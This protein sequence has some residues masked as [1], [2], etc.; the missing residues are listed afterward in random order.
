MDADS[1][2]II[3]DLDQEENSENVDPDEEVAEQVQF[4]KGTTTHGALALWFRGHRYVRRRTNCAWFRC[5]KRFCPAGAKLVDEEA[6]RNL[7]I[8]Q[9]Q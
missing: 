7:H 5:E 9:T 4:E 1:G 3:D 2:L 8:C 6:M